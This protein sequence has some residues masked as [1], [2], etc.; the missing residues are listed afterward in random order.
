[1]KLGNKENLAYKLEYLKE[2]LKNLDDYQT[3]TIDLSFSE[4]N[5]ARFTPNK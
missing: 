5:E 2:V 4:G 1:M 3:G